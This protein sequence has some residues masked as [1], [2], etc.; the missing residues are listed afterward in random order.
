M[1]ENFYF[2]IKMV[3]TVC[4]IQ[5]KILFYDKNMTETIT[6]TNKQFL[7]LLFIKIM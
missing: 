1:A 7:N 4:L 6:Y 2:T 3:K 5:K